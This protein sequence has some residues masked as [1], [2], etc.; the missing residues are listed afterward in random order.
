MAKS[1]TIEWALRR[2]TEI[3][4]DHRRTLAI[5]PFI[6]RLVEA[7]PGAELRVASHDKHKAA[8]A[9]FPGR[10][11][12]SRIPTVV[13]LDSRWRVLGYWSERGKSDRAWMSNFIQSDPLPEITL[14][15]GMPVGDFA[16]WLVRRFTGQLPVFYERNWEDVREELR[17][18][19]SPT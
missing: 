10:G 3:I 12:V 15:N 4:A 1:N 9:R 7:S 2:Q 6:A 18:L 14:V 5:A 13:L 17:I 16:Q 19:A 8:A 11:G